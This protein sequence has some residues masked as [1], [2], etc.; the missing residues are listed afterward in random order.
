MGDGGPQGVEFVYADMTHDA[1]QWRSAQHHLA[2]AKRLAGAEVDG[3]PTFGV[4]ADVVK[5][6]YLSAARAVRDHLEGGRS[7][8]GTV[9]ALIDA[10]TAETTSRDD[11]TDGRV[12]TAGGGGVPAPGGGSPTGPGG[13]PRGGG[14]PE[15]TLE[16]DPTIEPVPGGRTPLWLVDDDRDGRPDVLEDED[17]DGVLDVWE[18]GRDGGTPRIWR[19]RDHDGVPDIFLDGDSDGVADVL[20]DSDGDGTADLLEDADGDGRY[21]V[22]EDTKGA[23]PRVPDA[24][25]DGVPD[26]WEDSDGDGTVDLAEDEDRDGVADLVDDEVAVPVRDEAEVLRA[27]VTDPP[28]AGE[29]VVQPSDGEPVD[30]EWEPAVRP[31]PTAEEWV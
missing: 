22:W 5:E 30:G 11:N 31:R 26:L 29:G 24:D 16:P 9:A 1:G 27:D 2:E 10:N 7:A 4:Y 25:D 14:E 12:R 3:H 17:R 8:T 13:G 28:G 21:D 20:Q 6:T 23:P 15:A 18:T 19:D